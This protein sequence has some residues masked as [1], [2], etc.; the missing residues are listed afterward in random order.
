MSNKFIYPEFGKP[1]CSFCRRRIATK[2]CDAPIKRL[3]WVG[4][5]PRID[6]IFDPHEPMERTFTCNRPICEECATEIGDGID[7]CP[8]CMERIKNEKEKNNES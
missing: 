2:L 7:F 6:G 4:H 5:P 8:S 3:R 1:L